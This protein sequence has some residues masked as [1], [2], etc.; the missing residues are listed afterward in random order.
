MELLKKKIISKINQLIEHKISTLDKEIKQAIESRD[1]STKS[2]AG[3]K[4]ETSR[5]LIQI[6]LEKLSNQL[7]KVLRE[8]NELNNLITSSDTKQVGKGSL[9]KASNG[10]YFIGIAIGKIE[11]DNQHYFCISTASPIGKLL[12]NKTVGENIVF[13]AEKI[14]ILEIH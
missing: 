13:K 12:Y 3:D 1:E 6:E 14:K 2:S 8:K 7:K 9:V 4:H 11:F 5:A 10:I